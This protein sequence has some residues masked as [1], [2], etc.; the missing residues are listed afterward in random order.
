MIPCFAVAVGGMKMSHFLLQMQ[1][2][3]ARRAYN[4]STGFAYDQWLCIAGITL[5][6]VR[7]LLRSH[8]E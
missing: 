7:L 8:F 3:V 1:N 2:K 5:G 4:S 6:E